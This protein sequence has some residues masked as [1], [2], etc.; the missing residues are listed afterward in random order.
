M[1]ALIKVPVI[2]VGQ[3]DLVCGAADYIICFIPSGGG[4]R[5]AAIN[6]K[7]ILG[8]APINSIDHIVQQ[9]IALASILKFGLSWIRLRPPIR[10]PGERL[11]AFIGLLCYAQHQLNG[12][13][14]ELEVCELLDGRFKIVPW[15]LF[16]HLLEQIQALIQEI[17]VILGIRTSFRGSLQLFLGLEND[18][19][20]CAAEAATPPS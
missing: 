1:P 12:T 9:I 3:E 2:E 6:E 8:R 13:R 5:W 16:R 10:Y 20:L 11:V 7:G 15:K 18:D 19:V 14:V 17:P 4:H